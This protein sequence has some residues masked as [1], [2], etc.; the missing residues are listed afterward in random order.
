MSL[1]ED[2]MNEYNSN[3]PRLDGSANNR[4]D[5]IKIL[6]RQALDALLKAGHEDEAVKRAKEKAD[7]AWDKFYTLMGTV[8]NQVKLHEQERKDDDRS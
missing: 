8:M 6:N 3:N 7:R 2:L 1:A 4:H 5:Y